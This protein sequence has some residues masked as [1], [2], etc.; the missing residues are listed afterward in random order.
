[1][2]GEAEAGSRVGS[3]YVLDQS[4]GSGGMGTVWSAHRTDTGETVAIKILS[5]NL[6]QDPDLVARFLRERTAL[7][8]V[9]HPNLVEIRDLVVENQRIALVM[10]I[11]QGYDAARLLESNGPLP[12]RETARLGAEIAGALAAV[13]AGGIVHRDLKPAN[14][15]VE[16]STGQA[17][18]VDFGI[19]WI[20]KNPRL[21]AVN[22][23]VGTPH[24]LAPELLTGGE[25]SPAAD[26]YALAICLYQLLSGIVPFD[27]EHYAQI[28]HKHLNEAP[29]PHPSIP[30]TMWSVI[31][32]MLAKDPAAR[33]GLDFVAHQLT[34]FGGGPASVDR[35]A[36][37]L[38]PAPTS[39]PTPTPAPRPTS[40]PMPTSPPTPT[41]TPT[42]VPVSA[43]VPTP[44]PSSSNGYTDADASLFNFAPPPAAYGAFESQ[45]ADPWSGPSTFAPSPPPFQPRLEPE[46]NGRRRVLLIVALVLVFCGIGVGAWAFTAGGGSK[47]VAGP[48]ASPKAT[49]QALAEHHWTLCCNQLQDRSGNTNTTDNGV[50]LNSVQNGTRRSTESRARRSSWTGR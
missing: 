2:N 13:H 50:L 30:P 42:P 20:A 31:Q 45:A 35:P 48:T 40:T 43:P 26:I 46:R 6:V 37:A 27:G 47:P 14:I 22:S 29:Q 1:M 24:Y 16:S 8:N 18:L 19:A 15:L 21:T 3:L 11:V 28:L 34:M 23:V 17:K 39:Q 25:I 7:M 33:P 9:H 36:L 10:E 4:I 49:V 44:V 38:P 32:A 5:E 41:P 12:L